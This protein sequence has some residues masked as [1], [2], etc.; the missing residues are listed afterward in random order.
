[1]GLD[2][3]DINQAKPRLL[4]PPSNLMPCQDTLDCALV[5]LLWT[6]AG[7]FRVT[8]DCSSLEAACGKAR[9]GLVAFACQED[10]MCQTKLG[11]ATDAFNP[12]SEALGRQR[13][14]HRAAW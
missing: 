1:M 4:Q 5:S 2:E 6:E 3:G 12:S 10:F 13:Q 8:L 14:L 9:L 7:L 11:M